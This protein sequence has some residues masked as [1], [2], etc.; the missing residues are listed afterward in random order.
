ML[1]QNWNQIWKEKK[2]PIVVSQ[3][4]FVK[5]YQMFKSFKGPPNTRW[6]WGNWL[7]NIVAIS[8]AQYMA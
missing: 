5:I 2:T 4:T 1:L 6:Y 8:E 3:I 7:F